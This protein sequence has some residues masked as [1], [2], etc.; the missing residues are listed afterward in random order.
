MCVFLLVC[1]LFVILI[2]VLLLFYYF[3]VVV[4]IPILGQGPRS[5]E[6]L[7]S[8]LQHRL[9]FGDDSSKLYKLKR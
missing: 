3:V 8:N 7:S 6:M 2:A 9:K 1:F 5:Y 4:V